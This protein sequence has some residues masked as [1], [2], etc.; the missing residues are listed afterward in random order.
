M[1]LTRHV[2]LARPRQRPYDHRYQTARQVNRLA[3]AF[4]TK[5]TEPSCLSSPLEVCGLG[6]R[7]RYVDLRFFSLAAL[8]T[9]FSLT[10]AYRCVRRGLSSFVAQVL[11]DPNRHLNLLR[12][13]RTLRRKCSLSS[14]LG[15]AEGHEGRW[16]VRPDRSTPP[17]TTPL[18][19]SELG[20]GSI[21][22]WAP[23]E[24]CCCHLRALGRDNGEGIGEAGRSQLLFVRLIARA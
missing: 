19:H 2:A 22:D 8:M 11:H 12:T 24:G 10:W 4:S 9:G 20:S 7:W 17:T 21:R 15:N 1:T 5:L 3:A 23:V 6:R 18:T 14:L 16:R 13:H